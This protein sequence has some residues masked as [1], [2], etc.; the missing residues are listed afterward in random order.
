MLSTTPGLT[1]PTSFD[2][3]DEDDKEDLR[4]SV[5]LHAASKGNK[6]RKNY[7]LSRNA[8]PEKM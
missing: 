6:R 8:A 2:P 4:G 3:K 1:A 5:A 7:P